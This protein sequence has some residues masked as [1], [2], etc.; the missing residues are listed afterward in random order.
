MAVLLL[1]YL[2]CSLRLSLD[3][4]ASVLRRRSEAGFDVEKAVIFRKSF[5]SARRARFDEGRSERNGEVGEGILPQALTIRHIPHTIPFKGRMEVQ[6]ECIMRL[7]TLAKYNETADEPLKNA[8][9]AAA[10]S[11]MSCL[12][13]TSMN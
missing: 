2:N 4:R 10:V 6:G 7:S 11:R 5:A 9:N 1:L 12:P 13:N 3:S 8:R